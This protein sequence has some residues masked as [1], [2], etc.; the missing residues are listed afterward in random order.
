MKLAVELFPQAKEQLKDVTFPDPTIE[1]LF[2]ASAVI[3]AVDISD[4]IPIIEKAHK[5][6]VTTKDLK[7][8][9][10]KLVYGNELTALAEQ[11]NL[12]G[13]VGKVVQV[14]EEE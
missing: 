9:V 3:C 1:D 12:A 6:K 2:D 11:G 7:V 8:Q 5:C 13:I 10:T 4:F 14:K